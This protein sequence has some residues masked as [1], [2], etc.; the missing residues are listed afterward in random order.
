VPHVR[1]GRVRAL[2]VTSTKRS[3]AAPDVPTIAETALPG[4]EAAQWYGVVAPAKTPA[5]IITRLHAETV[6][7][8][9]LPEVREKFAN[10]GADTV[11]NS[12][13]EF[14]RFIRAELEKWSKAGRDAGIKPEG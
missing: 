2:G 9:Q 12:P 13:D 7:V 8:L 10:D 4:Y 6:R 1:T 3:N 5:D 14:A 11:G